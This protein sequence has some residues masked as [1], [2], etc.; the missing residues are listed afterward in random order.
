MVTASEKLATML[1]LKESDPQKYR[2]FVI[3][4]NIMYCSSWER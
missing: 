3:S 2:S 1:A 4:Y